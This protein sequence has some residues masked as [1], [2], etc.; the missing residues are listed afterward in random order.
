MKRLVTLLLFVAASSAVAQQ[1]PIDRIVAVVGTH[2][3]L[4]SQL[5]EEIVQLQ[6]QG[7]PLPPDSAGRTKLRRDVLE[8]VA[9][10]GS[11]HPGGSLSSAEKI[12]RAHV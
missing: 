11:G 10:A 2:P 6:A 9:A 12:G 5:E 8:M 7:R 3:I 4:A 1:Q